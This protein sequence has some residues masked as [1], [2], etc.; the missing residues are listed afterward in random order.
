MDPIFF[1]VGSFEI[2][3]YSIFIL[4]GV[5]SAIFLILREGK[6]FNYSKDFLFNLAFWTIIFGFIGA[7]TYYVIFNFSLYKDNLLSILEIWNGGLAIHGGIIAG[8]ITILI[9]CKSYNVKAVK[10]IDIIAP[11]LL[12][13]QAIGRWGNF[14]N[15][16]A[17]GSI[18]TYENLKNLYIPEFIIDGMYINENY[19]HPTFFYESL[20]CLLGFIVLIIVRRIKYIK[21]GQMISIYMIWYGVGRFLLESMRDYDALLLG[22]IRV[23]QIVSVI[24]II[25]GVV[26]TMIL[27]RKGKFENLYNGEEGQTIY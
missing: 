20:W 25:A 7:R 23:A 12:L 6:R 17:Y 2:M 18:T 11:A 26:I 3:W 9:Y 19:Y 24:M 22:G 10:V 13:A 1:R 15:S 21:T 27:S 5:I 14:F 4:L 16:E 8:L